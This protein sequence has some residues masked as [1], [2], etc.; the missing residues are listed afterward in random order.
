MHVYIY[1][2]KYHL[3]IPETRRSVKH[4]N[5]KR[6]DKKSRTRHVRADNFCTHSFSNNTPTVTVWRAYLVS[7]KS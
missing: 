2:Y 4:H 1:I 5:N 3:Y 6:T 7:N